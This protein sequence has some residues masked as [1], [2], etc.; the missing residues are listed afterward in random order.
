MGLVDENQNKSLIKRTTFGFEED[1][2][3]TMLKSN[4]YSSKL[5]SDLHVKLH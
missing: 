1:D 3:L 5:E 4:S 2:K